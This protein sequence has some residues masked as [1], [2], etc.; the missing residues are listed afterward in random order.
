MAGYGKSDAGPHPAP[1]VQG[2]SRKVPGGVR[3]PEVRCLTPHERSRRDPRSRRLSGFA[4]ARSP[5]IR[6]LASS[7]CSHRFGRWVRRFDLRDHCPLRAKI[8]SASP[9]TTFLGEIAHVARKAVSGGGDPSGQDGV[10]VSRPVGAVLAS[11]ALAS[12][13]LGEMASDLARFCPLD[14]V[15][16]RSSPIVPRVRGHSGICSPT[17]HLRAAP[18]DHI[19]SYQDHRQHLLGYYKTLRIQTIVA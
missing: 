10:T 5:G 18:K 8:G 14:T 1:Q 6:R 15:R 4:A 17:N 19:G 3:T 9:W 7:A 16:Y 11:T 13:D 2:A 12:S